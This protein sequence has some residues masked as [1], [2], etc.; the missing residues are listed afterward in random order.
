LRRAFFGLF[1]QEEGKK[2]MARK[3]LA[4]GVSLDLIASSAGLPIERIRASIN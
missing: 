2:E 4:N 1:F 3:L